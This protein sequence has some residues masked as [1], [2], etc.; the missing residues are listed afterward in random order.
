LRSTPPFPTIRLSLSATKQ[1]SKD[2]YRETVEVGSYAQA[3]AS[4]D[5]RARED[6][7]LGE[8]LQAIFD[9]DKSILEAE[10]ATND[11]GRQRAC[12]APS[13][14]TAPAIDPVARESE[15]SRKCNT[16]HIRMG[17]G[18]SRAME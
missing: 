18:R 15:F 9:R 5:A 16:M 14:R 8:R 1:F 17:S 4:P 2:G 12:R 11:P 10:N 13:A 3:I 7:V 6:A